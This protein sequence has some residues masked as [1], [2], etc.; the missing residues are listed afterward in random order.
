MAAV[1][2]G[3]YPFLLVDLILRHRFDSARRA[4]TI[5]APML[6][7]IGGADTIVPPRRGKALAR[8]WRGP[9]TTVVLPAAGHNDIGFHPAYWKTIREFLRKIGTDPIFLT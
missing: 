3:H 9:V 4:R 5:D 2:R 7:L 1:G 8:A 6:A